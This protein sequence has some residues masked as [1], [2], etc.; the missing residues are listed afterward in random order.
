MWKETDVVDVAF[1]SILHPTRRRHFSRLDR[2]QR[3]RA[4]AGHSSY[5]DGGALQ[6]TP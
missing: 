3:P 1:M 6:V 4:Q 5:I 2:D